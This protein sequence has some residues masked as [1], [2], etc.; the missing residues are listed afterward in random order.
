MF[1]VPA[2]ALNDAQAAAWGEYRWGAGEGEDL[3]FLTI[4]TGIGGGAVLN[5]RLLGG[6]AGHFG[7]WRS[8]SGGGPLEDEVSGRWLAAQAR[9]A[10]YDISA[11]D[12]FTAASQGEQ[13]AGNA[14]D[15][16]AGKVAALCSDIQLALDPR[17]IVIGGGIGLAAGFLDLVQDRLSHLPRR[18]RPHIAAARLGAQAGLVGAAD[19]ASLNPPK[20]MP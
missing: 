8:R 16:S 5:H 3:V 9:T 6:L 4:S 17:R 12:V 15:S 1:G 2:V 13:W 11:K 10:G 19:F 18:F 20:L 7:L 14:I